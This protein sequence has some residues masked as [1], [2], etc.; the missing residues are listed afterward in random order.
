VWL[1]VKEMRIPAYTLLIA[2]GLVLQFIALGYVFSEVHGSRLVPILS[3][4]FSFVVLFCLKRSKQKNL[5]G[6]L[7]LLFSIIACV[8]SINLSLLYGGL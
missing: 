3:I 1:P 4:A 6:S 2:F 7:Y 5:L 8:F